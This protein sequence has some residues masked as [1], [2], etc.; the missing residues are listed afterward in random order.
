M[1]PASVGSFSADGSLSR[2]SKLGAESLAVAVLFWKEFSVGSD[3]SSPSFVASDAL[4]SG[5]CG[6]KNRSKASR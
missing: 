1:R 6:V 4:V 2:S 5:C 3:G